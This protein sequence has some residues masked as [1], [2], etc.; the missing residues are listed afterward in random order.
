MV[1]IA[2][3]ICAFVSTE[4]C[5]PISGLI[6]LHENALWSHIGFYRISDGWTF[7]AMADGKG[8]DWRK[9]ITDAKILKLN[10]PGMDLAFQRALTKQGEGYDFLNIL[11][12]ALGRDWHTAGHLICS[13]LFFW[14]FQDAGVSPLNMR[15]LQLDKFEPYHILLALGTTEHTA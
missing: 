1:D 8:V 12:I 11:G 6:R 3:D 5:D 15:F 2:N 13:G 14:A 9:P 10:V 4:M 7:S